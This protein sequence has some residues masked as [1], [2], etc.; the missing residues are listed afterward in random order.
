MTS[1]ASAL[2]R[3]RG[4]AARCPHPRS[5]VAA[6]RG[7][8][9]LCYSHEHRSVA[10]S[11]DATASPSCVCGA[12][13]RRARACV[14]TASLSHVTIAKCGCKIDHLRARVRRMVSE[15]RWPHDVKEQQHVIARNG[16]HRTC[17]NYAY[18]HAT[19]NAARASTYERPLTSS[20]VE[21][22]LPSRKRPYHWDRD[23]FPA[24]GRGLTISTSS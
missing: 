23:M 16:G 3:G 2:A 21:E 1:C 7:K 5:S 20:L 19:C 24:C 6:R 8:L 4:V 15:A 10:H 22:V 12:R 18:A 14:A 11:A 17:L 13:Q 9:D